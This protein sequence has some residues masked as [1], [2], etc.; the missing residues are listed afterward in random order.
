MKY[1]CLALMVFGMLLQGCDSEGVEYCFVS[2]QNG[3]YYLV[4]HRS[5]RTDSDL[6]VYVT[7]Q[8]A[9]DASTRMNCRMLK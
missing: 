4:G 7:A 5:W 9:I 6:G 3:A 1:V 8:D 2:R